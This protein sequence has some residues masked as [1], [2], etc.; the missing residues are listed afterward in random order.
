MNWNADAPKK[1]RLIHDD[2][3]T[4]TCSK[5]LTMKIDKAA[6]ESMITRSA[7]LRALICAHLREE[8]QATT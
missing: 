6:D 1:R 5:A 8:K 7:W 2:V 3:I 4:F